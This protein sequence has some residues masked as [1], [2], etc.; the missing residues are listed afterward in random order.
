MQ[1]EINKE[2][3]PN[4]LEFNLS[5][6]FS[7]LIGRQLISNPTV[8]VL[9]LVKNCYDADAENISVSFDYIKTSHGKITI[10]DDGDGM[11]INDLKTKWMVIGT[12]N[13][14]HDPY[15]N[16]K[17]RKL[18]EKGIGRFSVERLACKTTIRTTT[19]GSSQ[20]VELVIDWNKYGDSKEYFNKIKHPLKYEIVDKDTTGTTIILEGL[21]DE[22]TA[23]MIAN[24][25]K[26][27]FLLIPL[28]IGSLSS[29][30]NSEVNVSLICSDFPNKSGELQENLL[31]YYHAKL[32]GVINED[33]S[34]DL[35]LNLRMN[36]K[37]SKQEVGVSYK[38]KLNKEEINY[39]CGPLTFEA[40]AFLRDGRLY[41][42]L[43][44][45]KDD[46]TKLLDEYCGIKIY[47]DDFRV[48][49]YGDPDND[50]LN[51]NLRR[52]QSPEY[53][54]ATNQVIG[55]VK[56]GRD[57]NPG[58][59]DV[60]SRENLYETLEFKD[61][62]SF[63][64]EVF[65]FYTH[66]S[67]VENRNKKQDVRDT[68]EELYT[69]IIEGSSKIIEGSAVLQDQ[70]IKGLER[71]ENKQNISEIDNQNNEAT[72]NES[73]QQLEN[74]NLNNLLEEVKTE[75]KKMNELATQLKNEAETVSEKIKET[76]NFKIRETQI[77][78]NIASLGISA[79]QFGHETE[80]L[81][82][83]SVLALRSINRF[84]E[85]KSITN[86][87]LLD[88]F[89]HL[90]RY[91]TSANQKAD[92]FRG[93]LMREKQEDKRIIDVVE[94][95][96]EI[97]NS[98]EK[99]FSGLN[100]SIE[101]TDNTQKYSRLLGYYGDIE[102]IATNIFTNAYKALSQGGTDQKFLNISFKMEDLDLVIITTNSGKPIDPLD[103]QHIFQPLFS[104]HK[105]GTGLG[106]TII[107]DTL[108][109][110]GGSINLLDEYPLS[111]FELHIPI[112][113]EDKI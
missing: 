31:K 17:R 59:Q 44:F 105:H 53:R 93:Y 70:I 108:K 56:I 13:K 7:Q 23:E 112:N 3:Q 103:R 8:A 14:M 34:A 57:T 65:D 4:E 16:K 47:R 24:L 27:L 30:F 6:R 42:G 85:I 67:F 35:E 73:S 45:N 40:Y 51:L 66:A 50:W 63:I 104:T 68:R 81:I 80:K 10:S 88:E 109:T 69:N 48:K 111:I 36:K 20:L 76:E 61:L 1:G 52:V 49:P 86:A 98:F 74:V 94:I 77:Y 26:E 106:L 29:K 43:D 92:F 79:A 101:I 84:D 97:A 83:N 25:R 28:D 32:F 9:E 58:L 71:L 95:F 72:D 107:E 100:A 37:N 91:L 78:R 39:S 102:S 2:E 46:I 75:Y 38:R 89:S 41:R 11:T 110:Y 82:L 5:S 22:W 60:L 21:R 96:R 15:T 12:D 62:I 113:S 55:G 64:N 19:F 54:L 18:G 33:G 99:S 87:L 90:E